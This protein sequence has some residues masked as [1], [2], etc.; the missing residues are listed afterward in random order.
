MVSL[1]WWV[2][3]VLIKEWKSDE[4]GGIRYTNFC[5]LGNLEIFNRPLAH[6]G[7]RKKESKRKMSLSDLPDEIMLNIFQYSTKDEIKKTQT[8]EFLS[9]FVKQ[10]TMFVEWRMPLFIFSL[11]IKY[12]DLSIW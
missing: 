7:I 1:N 4:S 9:T 3:F 5:A 2:I 11:L 12:I 8:K 6:S 10:R